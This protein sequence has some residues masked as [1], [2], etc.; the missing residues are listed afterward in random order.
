MVMQI[1]NSLNQIDYKNCNEKDIVNVFSRLGVGSAI[2]ANY[3]PGTD[4]IPPNFF[5]RS[6]I[7]NPTIENIT[8]LSRLS[9]PPVEINYKYGGYQR[10]STPYRSMFYATRLQSINEPDVL[11]SIRTCLKESIKDYDEHVSN[12]NRVMLSLWYAYHRI[13]L[14]SIFHKK[15]FLINNK[16][17]A[18]VHNAFNEWQK[19]TP[20]TI[21]NAT[22]EILEYLAERFA[23]PVGEEH[24]TY[25]PSGV[26][27]QYLIDRLILNGYPVDGVVFPSTKVKGQELNIAI[28]PMSVDVK[29]KCCRIL[30]CAFLPNEIIQIEK[31]VNINLGQ[32]DFDLQDIE[33]TVVDLKK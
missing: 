1:I 14:F 23:I 6:T 15:E 17:M 5:T 31:S 11:S 29:L 13:N 24:H 30:D 10:A 22:L 26:I 18:E 20:K 32:F 7:Y 28:N 3:H 4:T 12:G 33:P 8:N 9:Y 27:S 19:T 2:I 16:H 21:Q 25:K